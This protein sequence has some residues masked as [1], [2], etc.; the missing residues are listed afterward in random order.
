MLASWLVVTLFMR[1]AGALRGLLTAAV[2]ALAS[3]GSAQ[4]DVALH[5]DHGEGAGAQVAPEIEEL[6]ASHSALHR[7]AVQHAQ[8]KKA[9][10]S[11]ANGRPINL[12]VIPKSPPVCS[13]PVG[14]PSLLRFLSDLLPSRV[15]AICVVL[16]FLMLML[17]V[18]R[19]VTAGHALLRISDVSCLPALGRAH[20]RRT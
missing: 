10:Q 11:L 13:A 17:T 19:W 20:F 7:A 5:H 18:V 9:E 3:E 16:V 12:P 15:V 2:L 1:R 8:H 14:P 4:A 6:L